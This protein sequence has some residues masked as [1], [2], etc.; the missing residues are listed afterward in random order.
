M[1]RRKSKPQPVRMRDMNLY[2]Y[3]LIRL[4]MIQETGYTK[5][6]VAKMDEIADDMQRYGRKWRAANR[7]PSPSACEICIYTITT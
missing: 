2:D 7:S 3:N 6:M 5:E 1:A 4:H